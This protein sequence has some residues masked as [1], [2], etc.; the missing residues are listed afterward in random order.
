M[1]VISVSVSRLKMKLGQYMRAVRDGG[2]FVIT[3]R[4]RPVARLM[5]IESAVEEP[6]VSRPRDPSAPPL[7]EVEV[8]GIGSGRTDTLTLL[9]EDRNAR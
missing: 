9:L 6:L 7:G 1:S 4:E 5:P 8:G 2:H 3:D